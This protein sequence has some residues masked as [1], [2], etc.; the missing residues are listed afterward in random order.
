VQDVQ[1]QRL[2]E[3]KSV[4]A[5]DT[6]EKALITSAVTTSFSGSAC[7]PMAYVSFSRPTDFSSPDIS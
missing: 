7:M 1:M 4:D 3:Q 6:S 5:P 2:Q